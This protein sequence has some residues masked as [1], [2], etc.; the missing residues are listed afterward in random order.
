MSL[1][2]GGASRTKR[3]AFMDTQVLFGPDTLD[4]V[5]ATIQVDDEPVVV[6]AHALG[7]GESV[8]VEMV[9]GPGE[10]KYFTPYMMAGCQVVMTRKCNQIAIAVPGRYRFILDGA[11]GAAYVIA[12]SASMTHEFLLGVMNMGGCC[13]ESPTSLP[14]N[15]PAGGDLDGTYPNPTIDG[16]KAI[17]RIMGDTNAK[18]LLTAL[19]ESLIPTSLPPN[20]PAGGGLT[21]TYPN[22]SI[23]TTKLAQAISADASAQQLLANALCDELNE[24]VSKKIPTTTPPSGPARGDLTGEY[25]APEID[26]QKAVERIRLNAAALEALATYLCPVL[27]PCIKEAATP[28]PDQMAAVFKRCDGSKQVPGNALATCDEVDTKIT[29][30]IGKIP[31]DKFLNLVGYDP[32]THV[33]SFTVGNGGP[34]FTINLSDLVPIKV[35][36]GLTGDG[37]IATPAAVKVKPSGGLTAGPDGVA[38]SLD[39]AQ[40]APATTVGDD[41]P[42]TVF[43]GRG[44]LLG[45]PDG[46]FVIEGKNVP[47]WN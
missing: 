11:V 41:L 38:L 45:A 43:G 12:F 46:W 19:L 20:G 39:I 10:G 42:T 9:D 7:V 14:P 44:A 30:A 17:G 33:L 32:A 21:G 4:A 28:D 16:L 29:E 1:N 22:P 47:Y 13:G 15:G 35:G 18:A 40:A 2:S 36:D 37:T 23:D 26:P 25:P 5:S 27:E 31:L 24:C 6:R 3:T 34:T 8:R